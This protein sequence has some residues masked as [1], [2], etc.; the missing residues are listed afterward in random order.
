[1]R[2]RRFLIREPMAALK[3]AVGRGRGTTGARQASH[4][5]SPAT[6]GRATQI[7]KLRVECA[8]KLPDGGAAGNRSCR[9]R[10]SRAVRPGH[11]AADTAAVPGPV[12][13]RAGPRP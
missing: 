11:D 12:S 8:D 9:S 6:E 4:V 2:L 1:M 5:R 13:G 10:I 7:V 3:L